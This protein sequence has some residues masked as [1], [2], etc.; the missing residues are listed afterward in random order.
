MGERLPDRER[1]LRRMTLNVNLTAT[2]T[3]ANSSSDDM[4]GRQRLALMH[5]KAMTCPNMF[6]VC[7]DLR[8][9][10]SHPNL[11]QEQWVPSSSTGQT[12]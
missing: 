8:R 5:S 7:V 2:T 12:V 9:W 11:Q 3:T 10:A 4:T 1:E 6:F